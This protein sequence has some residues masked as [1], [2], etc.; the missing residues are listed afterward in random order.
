M[1]VLFWDVVLC[2]WMYRNCCFGSDCCFCL[3]GINT[4]WETKPFSVVD[5]YKRFSLIFRLLLECWRWIR[6]AFSIRLCA[7]T[8]CSVICQANEIPIFISYCV[9]TLCY[10]NNN[11]LVWNLKNYFLSCLF[12]LGRRDSSVGIATGY[13]LDG[14]GIDSRWG[15]T[16]SAPVQTGPGAHPASYT[17]GT[18]SF[19]GVKR[20]GRGVDHPPPSSAEVKEGLE[21][22]L[23]SPPG[24]SWPVIGW[25]VPFTF[26]FTV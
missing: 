15:E 16:Y 13:G 1:S 23:Y 14:P 12:Y 10:S 26:T 6:H 5:V 25:T 7:A 24:P 4:V 18:G 11:N 20:P 17:M 22:Y 19:S 8:P 21:L 2:S 3:Q 9:V